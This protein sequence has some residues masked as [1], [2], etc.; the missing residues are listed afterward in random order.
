VNSKNGQIP[1]GY[2]GQIPPYD[3]AMPRGRLTDTSSPLTEKID[4]RTNLSDGLQ[5]EGGVCLFSNFGGIIAR[6]YN[7]GGVFAYLLLQLLKLMLR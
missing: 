6:F 5:F 7:F 4:G 2:Y 1:P 3:M